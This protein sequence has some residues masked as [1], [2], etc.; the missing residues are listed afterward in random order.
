MIKPYFDNIS[1]RIETELNKAEHEIKIAV[2]WITDNNIINKLIWKA[3]N[4]VKIEILISYKTFNE[5]HKEFQDKI[6]ERMS[7]P[8]CHVFKIGNSDDFSPLMHHKFCVI[9]NHILITGSYN[10]TTQA[11]RNYEDII[12]SDNFDLAQQYVERFIKL[13]KKI[14][15]ERLWFNKLDYVWQKK[16]KETIRIEHEPTEEELINIANLTILDISSV[17]FELR[18]EWEEELFLELTSEVK[19]LTEIEIEI[20]KQIVHFEYKVIDDLSPVSLMRNLQFINCSGTEIKN[21]DPLYDLDK[22]E[23]IDISFSSIKDLTPLFNKEKLKK[24]NIFESSV[25]DIELAE[26][27]INNPNCQI[28]TNTIFDDNYIA[29]F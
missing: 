27:K 16:L 7:M 19:N 4:G 11:K 28:S 18:Q 24:I 20:Y 1:E 17:P 14:S 13:K 9:D 23:E 26:F 10:W 15:N 3:L 5:K 29:P 6:I 25:T 22:L 8:N 12:V 21:I 2:A